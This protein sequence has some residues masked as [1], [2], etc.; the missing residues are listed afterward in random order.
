MLFRSTLGGLAAWGV[1]DELRQRAVVWTGGL[2][3]GAGR[4]GAGGYRAA[5]APRYDQLQPGFWFPN[6]AHDSFVQVG[7]VGGGAAWVAWAALLVGWS[8]AAPGAVAGVVGIT[9]GAM[10]QDTFGDLEVVRAAAT[11]IA[12]LGTATPTRG[13]AEP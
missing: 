6:H 4:A 8:A 10:T 11:W 1:T 7:A 5:S 12:I 2:L 3:V 13:Q 9:V